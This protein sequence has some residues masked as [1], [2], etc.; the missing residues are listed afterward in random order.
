LERSTATGRE[1]RLASSP[2]C[3]FYLEAEHLDWTPEAKSGLV[4]ETQNNKQ[5][6]LI[7]QSLKT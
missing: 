5:T 2:G 7:T 3:S 6:K 4:T 1:L